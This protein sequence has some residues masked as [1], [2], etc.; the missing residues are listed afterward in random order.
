MDR[1]IHPPYL[2]CYDH[3]LDSVSGVEAMEGLTDSPVTHSPLPASSFQ[4]RE[5]TMEPEEPESGEEEEE[6]EEDDEPILKY[7]RFQGA[8]IQ[9]ILKQY[10][11]TAITAHEK[12]MVRK[13]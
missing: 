8:G 2:A 9:D 10:S 1:I 6:D 7:S 4:L 13:K 11:I 3:L 5:R 12:M